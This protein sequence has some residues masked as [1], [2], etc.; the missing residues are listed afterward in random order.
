M[1]CISE[2]QPGRLIQ[3]V[4][5]YTQS[6]VSVAAIAEGIL[7]YPSRTQQISLPTFLTVLRCESPWELWIAAMLTWLGGYMS[8]GVGFIHQQHC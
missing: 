7:L 8:G 6:C 4:L 2:V 3:V 1:L 5:R